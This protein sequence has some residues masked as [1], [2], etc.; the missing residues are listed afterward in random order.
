MKSFIIVGCFLFAFGGYADQI[1]Q[2]T[3][4]KGL[5]HLGGRFERVTDF[6][7]VDELLV[8]HQCRSPVIHGKRRAVRCSEDRRQLVYDPTYDRFVYTSSGGDRFF[9]VH[10][11][12]PNEIYFSDAAKKQKIVLGQRI[13]GDLAKAIED[14][15][16]RTIFNAVDAR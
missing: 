11:N 4:I 15:L 14:D 9:R 8:V 2:E 16:A 13:E 6:V 7:F 12:W 1:Y 10:P 5:W 3:S